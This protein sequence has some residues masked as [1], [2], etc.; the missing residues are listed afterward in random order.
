MLVLCGVTP[1]GFASPGEGRG[2]PELGG[3]HG[4]LCWCCLSVCPHL[5]QLLLPAPCQPRV[6]RALPAP[7]CQSSSPP[8]PEDP[9]AG[10]RAVLGA[11]RQ[12]CKVTVTAAEVALPGRAG[13][14]VPGATRGWQEPHLGSPSRSPGEQISF[15]GLGRQLALQVS[16]CLAFR[17]LCWT[18]DSLS[19]RGCS[20]LG[21]PCPKG[22]I[23]Q[24]GTVLAAV[25][26]SDMGVALG[27]QGISP[28][29]R[30]G[31]EW[32]PQHSSSLHVGLAVPMQPHVPSG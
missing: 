23:W 12:R 17:A 8:W 2:C 19:P 6:R 4:G 7:R 27:D 31:T 3:A 16:C 30:E 11:L 9:C 18:G 10:P 22:G 5:L 25:V 1:L 21:S 26:G 28:G 24:Q 29:S 15:H 13:S 20:G 32:T 14:C